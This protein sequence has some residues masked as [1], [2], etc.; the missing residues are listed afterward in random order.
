MLKAFRGQQ[1]EHTHENKIFDALFDALAIHCAATQ[2]NWFLFGNFHIGNRELDALI[3]KPNALVV[4]DFK[5][6]T[7]K[8]N[9][10]ED[11]PWFIEDVSSEQ[12]IQ[13]KGGASVNPLI[14]LR[15]NK[16]ALAD[17]MG[18]V[19]QQCN[20]GHIAATVLFHDTIEFDTQQIPGHCKPWLHITDM[21]DI[22]RTLEAIVSREI[23][24]APKDV[25]YIV[26]RLG[27]PGFVPA[28]TLET[29]LLAESGTPSPSEDIQPIPS[30]KQA[31]AE[32]SDWL[33]DA[34]GVFRLLGM[35]STGKRFLFPFLTSLI[36]RAGFTPLLL[37][38]SARF[39][40]DYSCHDAQQSSIYTWLYSLSPT[41]FEEDKGQKIAVHDIRSNI[42]LRSIMPV[43][44]D[45]HLL[46]DEEF[47]LSDRRYGSG[48]L[49][50]DFLEVV[51]GTPFVVI[52]DPYQ[53]SRGSQSRSITSFIPPS[54]LTVNVRTHELKEQILASSG[55]AVNILQAHLRD[56]IA[57]ERFNHLPK[58]S[59][60]G[61]EIVE[62]YTAQRWAPDTENII[63]T[64]IY[65]CDTHEQVNRINAAAK[66]R[67]LH[68]DDPICLNKG[69]RIDFH[70]RTPILQNEDTFDDIETD[71]Q[72]INAGAIG[73]VDEIAGP[74]E[75]EKIRLQGREQDTVVRLQKISC[76]VA[77]LGEVKINYL[78]D[79]Y[80]AEKP[81]LSIDYEITLRDWARKRAEPILKR[82]KDMV[83]EDKKDPQYDEAKKKY[84]RIEYNI[85]QGQGV[86]TAARIRPAFALTVHR[87]QGQHWP[88]VWLNASRAATNDTYTNQTY[89]RWLYTATTC[90]DN[91]F[92]QNFP[93]IDPMLNA[94]IKRVGNIAIGPISVR[95]S[96]QYNKMRIASELESSIIPPS[97]FSSANLIPLL[98]EL[99]DRLKDS[100][101]GLTQWH[102][103][104]YQV[105]VILT[106]DTSNAEARVRLNY[107]DALSI[108]N[109]TFPDT[110]PKDCEL[111]SSLLLRPFVPES[112]TLAEVLDG[113]LAKLSQNG[114]RLLSAKENDY[115]ITGILAKGE[116]ALEFELNVPK[117][118]MV[119]SIRLLRA[120]AES[121]LREVESAF[122][123][124]K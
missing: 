25:Q 104:P 62:K 31:L 67:L 98:L 12:R 108:T 99:K 57:R 27:L 52:G 65:L 123:V 61:L 26:N 22:V 110:Q 113:F 107:D 6:F 40:G 18:N 80:E 38:P 11:G 19:S 36:R 63:P 120:T 92:I 75:I 68:H 5:D 8:L 37:A 7:G 30:Q 4:I 86:I 117:N 55:N 58:F 70:S 42:E 20:W 54:S 69:D 114:V 102:E 84:D 41:K 94:D 122:G 95:T 59:G 39:I 93:E 111:L 72:W 71:T 13:V 97:G 83:P 46:S 60:D 91:L 48:R 90:A 100:Q 79:F 3:I 101:W 15:Y 64:S 21:N 32:F 78:P 24:I 16:R 105:L 2:Q 82:Y 56:S 43:L 76:R 66:I 109:V 81:E 88:C 85:L 33:Q 9:I 106:S 34:K 49:I 44:V 116:D 74:I 50:S 17:F 53:M 103:Y 73:I 77:G 45:A 124:G 51:G 10:S 121:I 29:Y 115:K 96:L 112:Q 1:F 23:H 87:A 118:G 14:Q 35:A 47:K 89:F 28:S 119:R